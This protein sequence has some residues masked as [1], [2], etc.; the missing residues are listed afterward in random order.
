MS[1]LVAYFDGACEP[2]N[3]GGVASGGWLILSEESREVIESG[4]KVFF[5]GT[6][7]AT[8]NAAEWCA[9]GFALRTILDKQIFRRF[10]ALLICGDS[11]LVINQL[12]GEWLCRNE[13]MAMFCE[14]CHELLNAI[15]L[16]WAAEWIPRDENQRADALSRKAY[17]EFTGRKFPE[18][19]KAF[20]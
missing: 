14:R 15:R 13:R 6:R 16:P 8:N 9:L 10:G 2:K 5:H 18:R 3:P 7:E 20:R 1:R 4:Y 11:Q 12:T 19:R 17:E